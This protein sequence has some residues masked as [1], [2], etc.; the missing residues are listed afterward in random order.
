MDWIVQT[1]LWC[2]AQVFVVCSVTSVLLAIQRNPARRSST[3]PAL[4]MLMVLGVT[5][6]CLLP[7]PSLPL[8]VKPR[9]AAVPASTHE[10]ANPIVPREE[11]NEP[12]I[13]ANVITVIDLIRKIEM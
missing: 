1:T 12:A 11:S 3:M 7:L 13:S 4:A 6:F 5:V 9:D 10:G 2:V 8:P